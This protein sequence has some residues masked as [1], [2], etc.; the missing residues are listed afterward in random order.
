MSAVSPILSISW[1]PQPV[2]R[3]DSPA[4]L[5][6]ANSQGII[7][8]FEENTSSELQFLQRDSFQLDSPTPFISL[9][10]AHSLTPSPK[11]KGREMAACFLE[12]KCTWNE[13]SDFPPNCQ[14]LLCH[15][16]DR[17]VG[18]MFVHKPL[19]TPGDMSL[20]TSSL[21][22]PLHLEKD[23]SL[24]GCFTSEDVLCKEKSENSGDLWLHVLRHGCLQALLLKQKENSFVLNK[25]I[26][27][28]LGF[29]N[30]LVF[31][32]LT[33]DNTL[34]THTSQNQQLLWRPYVILLLS[35]DS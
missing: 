25:T 2:Y 23:S 28:Q 29:V 20:S 6:A 35:H 5:V 22:F 31:A 15:A 30:R 8:I 1:M 7:Q 33:A 17:V 16:G 13:W 12:G 11:T 34:I 14:L 19:T 32:T 10:W 21:S 3:F 9:T 26:S 4:V 18:R 24:V 27:S